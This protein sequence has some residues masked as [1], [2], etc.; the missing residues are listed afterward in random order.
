MNIFSTH[1]PQELSFLLGAVFLILTIC[2]LTFTILKK[3]KPSD[4]TSELVTRTK[5]WWYIMPGVCLVILG[6]PVVGAI[7]IGFVSC[8][9][10]REMFSISGMQTSNRKAILVAY[11][12][13]PIQY[14]LG[15]HF[16]YVQF[17]IFIPICMFMLI[18]FLLVLEGKTET[19]GR[20]MILI[21][22]LLMMTTYSLSH[23]VLLFKADWKGFDLGAGSLIFFLL[24][25]TAFN[26]VFQYTWGKLLGKRKILPRISPN[27]TWEGFVGGVLT[28]SLFAY[29]IRFLTP[30]SSLQ[31]LAMGLMIG[32]CGFMGDS[33]VSAIK[34]NL[35]LKDT[36]K[37][38]PGHGGAMDRLDSLIFTAPAFFHMLSFYSI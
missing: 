35:D 6:P 5:S 2:S 19:I 11:L 18:P 7:L 16:Y 13:I 36:G 1:I 38:I 8:V 14:Y 22:S 30:L 25:L 24:V 17:L 26:D 31:A 20:T 10:L 29:L 12:A 37:L 32:I 27:K 28:C 3:R 33:L 9:A 21:P 34:R 15:F 23:I 4:L